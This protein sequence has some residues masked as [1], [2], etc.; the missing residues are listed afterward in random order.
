MWKCIV[1]IVS[2]ILVKTCKPINRRHEKSYVN[3]YPIER[4]A[5]LLLEGAK[6]ELPPEKKEEIP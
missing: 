2:G 4:E 1:T 3:G 6:I 5:I